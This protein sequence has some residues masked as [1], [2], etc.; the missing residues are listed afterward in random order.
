MAADGAVRIST[1][2]TQEAPPPGAQQIDL[3]T[4]LLVDLLA[5]RETPASVREVANTLL[6]AHSTASRFV[7]RA[8]RSGAVRREG[9]SVDGRLQMAALTPAGRELAEKAREFRFA[10]LRDIMDGW[11]EEDVETLA[12][13]LAKFA[14]NT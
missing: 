13:L 12:R 5:S 4:V 8:V 2:Q 3:S 9:Q 6:V 14:S 11:D 1:A 7:E 10:R